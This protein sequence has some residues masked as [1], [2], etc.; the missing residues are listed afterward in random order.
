MIVGPV[1]VEGV[2]GTIVYDWTCENRKLTIYD[3]DDDTAI[4]IKVWGP[5]FD[6]QREEGDLS[7]KMTKKKLLEWLEHG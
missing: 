1:I 5:D 2:Y 6:T 4:Y 7:P 3:Y